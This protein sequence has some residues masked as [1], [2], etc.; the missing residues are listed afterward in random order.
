M[1]PT[2][3]RSSSPL[4]LDDLETGVLKL[5]LGE[6]DHRSFWNENIEAF[7]QTVL[8]AI[9]ETADALRSPGISPDWRNELEAQLESLVEYV[10]L[11]DRYA[12]RRDFSRPAASVH[13][14]ARPLIH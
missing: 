12:E 4:S 13:P 7:R 14:S 11:A 6:V 5:R 9:R 10:E 2:E 1:F 8:V 3:Q